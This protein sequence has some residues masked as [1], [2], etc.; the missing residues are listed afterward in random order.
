M[1]SF[2]VQSMSALIGTTPCYRRMA[3]TR[4][5]EFAR[6]NLPN[7]HKAFAWRFRQLCGSSKSIGSKAD[8][9]CIAGVAS[10]ETHMFENRINSFAP[11]VGPTGFTP[12]VFPTQSDA[13]A[14][15]NPIG[16]Q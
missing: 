7:S 5:T 15:P 8:H 16:V 12:G 13:A 3:A 2:K 11:N 9:E 4:G 10:T 14:Q 6:A 1:P